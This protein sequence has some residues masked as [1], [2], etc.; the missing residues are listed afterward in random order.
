[1]KLTR[2]TVIVEV[3]LYGGD[4]SLPRVT[5]LYFDINQYHPESSFRYQLQCKEL[6]RKTSFVENRLY[7]P[8]FTCLSLSLSMIKG[9]I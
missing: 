3:R 8:N 9:C 4:L 5:V 7:G 1:M 6:S 2:K